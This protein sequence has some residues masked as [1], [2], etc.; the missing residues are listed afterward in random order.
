[1]VQSTHTETNGTLLYTT[2]SGS[3]GWRSATAGQT[4]PQGGRHELETSGR[5]RGDTPLGYSGRTA[6]RREQCNGF[7]QASLYDRRLGAL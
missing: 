2:G 3:S 4:E 5:K 7:A 6:L 1:M